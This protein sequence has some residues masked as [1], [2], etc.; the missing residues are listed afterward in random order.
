MHIPH[1]TAEVVDKISFVVFPLLF[2]IF[3]IAF[4]LNVLTNIEK[5]KGG[6]R[7][8]FFSNTL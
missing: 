2:T 1:N 5:Q 4:W 6:P 3:N 8:T 7:H